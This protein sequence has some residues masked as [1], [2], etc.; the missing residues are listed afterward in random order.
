LA[1]E[2][3]GAVTAS[4]AVVGAVL[5]GV[6]P[7]LGEEA[8]GAALVTEIV[9]EEE[10][11]VAGGTEGGREAILALIWA[12]RTRNGPVFVVAGQRLAAVRVRVHG[13][14]IVDLITD[15]A[16]PINIAVVAVIGTLCAREILALLEPR[17]AYIFA[18]ACDAQIVAT[19]T[20]R[21]DRSVEAHRTFVLACHTDLGG[22]IEVAGAWQTTLGYVEVC[23]LVSYPIAAQALPG[24]GTGETVVGATGAALS[25]VEAEVAKRALQVAEAVDEKIVSGQTVNAQRVRLAAVAARGTGQADAAEVVEVPRQRHAPEC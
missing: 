5:A 4:E 14:V 7:T 25:A 16:V 6:G 1:A 11:V 12:S 23:A 21:A 2:A 10:A 9:D 22:I 24:L 17:L 18:C 19:D 8:V 3:G 20:G 15:R 13:S